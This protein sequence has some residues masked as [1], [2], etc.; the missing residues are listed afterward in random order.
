[1]TFQ[2]DGYGINLLKTGDPNIQTFMDLVSCLFKVHMLQYLGTMHQRSLQ[3][4]W[5]KLTTCLIHPL[6]IDGRKGETINIAPI[7]PG[8]PL[9]SSLKLAVFI[10]TPNEYVSLHISRKDY[11]Y[12]YIDRYLNICIF[13][14]IHVQFTTPLIILSLV[15]WH[16]TISLMIL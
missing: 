11:V 16:R 7:V 4:W 1:M 6:C 3:R 5:K 2:V 10:V 9:K 8:N 15:G 14:E 13:L 12:I